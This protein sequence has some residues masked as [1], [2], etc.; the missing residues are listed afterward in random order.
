VIELH[1]LH[2]IEGG[3]G[4]LRFLDCDD[5]LIA[6]LLHGLGHQ[7]ADRWIVVGG[8]GRN[9]CFLL[10]RLYRARQGLQFID[11][12]LGVPLNSTLIPAPGRM[13]RGSHQWFLSKATG[14][15]AL[16]LINVR[17]GPAV[18]NAGCVDCETK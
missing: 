17:G 9:L 7:F 6:D 3:F 4:G 2:Y 5:A 18:R 10:A 8:N 16:T 13:A 1:S 14:P 12:N 11:G 15:A